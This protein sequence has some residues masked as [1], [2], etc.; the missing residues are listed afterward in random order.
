MF[1]SAEALFRPKSIAIVGASDSGYAKRIFENLA[2]AQFPTD[3]FLI[4][5]RRDRIWERTVYKD[6]DALPKPPDLV[7]AVISESYIPESLAKAAACGVKASIVYASDFG[8]G[9][10][11]EG[12]ARADALRA[13]CDKGLR[14]CGPNCMGVISVKEQLCLY[15]TSRVRS[16]PSGPVG[17]VFQSGGTF[18]FWLQQGATRGLGYSYA[19]SS[20]NELD[21][22]VAD[23]INF[24]VE[25]ADT[26]VIICLIEGIRRPEA[27]C[28]AAEKALLAGKPILAVKIGR[29]ERGQA[30]TQ[31]HTGSLAGDD[32]V[33]NAV[34]TKYGIV[35]CRTLDD[36]IETALVFQTGRLPNGRCIAMVGFSGG[37]KGMFLDYA[38]DEKAQLA[39]LSEPTIAAISALIDKSVKPENPLDVGAAASRVPGNYT[40]ICRL[41]LS[42]PGVD[43]LA[44]Q[45][46]LPMDVDEP[47]SDRAQYADLTRV[48]NK[49][50]V[51]FGRTHQNVTPEGR[52]LQSSAGVPYLQ[53]I[54]DAIR[55]LQKSVDYAA[56]VRRG[57]ARAPTSV[58]SLSEHR[59][60]DI[61]ELLPA[62][63]IGLPREAL[64]KTSG[65]A[66]VAAKDIG[67]PVALK[68]VSPEASH[69]T[70][71]GG[72]ALD[73]KDADQVESRAQA[74]L[75]Q[76]KTV[77]PTATVEGFLVQEMVSGVEM[78][79]GARSDPL[80]G[81][82]IV[83]GFGGVTAEL[84]KD[85]S[86][87]LAP[88]DDGIARDM[89]ANLRGAA[90]LDEFRGRPARDLNALAQ[91]LTALAQL[92]CD[93][94]DWI[95]E[96][97]INPLIVRE[98]GMGVCAVDVRVVGAQ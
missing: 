1:R 29:S 90:L 46:Q 53:G 52:A 18:Q 2:A 7:L 96:I 25:D 24:M 47:G 5:P 4:N 94:R 69:K 77:H 68:I 12:R 72:V 50:I 37:T 62:Y 88:I 55:A 73:L 71:V 57:V 14:V 64:V 19:V 31:T 95:S 98:A 44:L 27:F 58:R 33:F 34:C 93:N 86:I 10:S 78:I 56:A 11:L 80:F 23:Y 42:D 21:L 17:V 6:Y 22:D 70:E 79:V 81:P 38:A 41:V 87:R 16:L 28:A 65:E 89:L 45:G 13:I 26:K 74:M 40:E 48:T 84:L 83:A 3:I 92:Y 36:L 15:P 8:E 51:V 61:K 32:D 54:P 76:L 39:E 59:G 60:L 35:R 67:Y 9:G 97:E 20:G 49:P 30:S 82:I 85:V 75:K 63:G 91:A 43:I 66:A